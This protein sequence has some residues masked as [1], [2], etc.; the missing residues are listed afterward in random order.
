[1]TDRAFRFFVSWVVGTAAL[2]VV[3]GAV[4]FAV[5][6]GRSTKLSHTAVEEYIAATYNIEVVCNDGKDMPIG[7]G[8]S[9]PCSGSGVIVEVRMLDGVGT[10]EIDTG[11]SNSTTS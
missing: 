8:R 11:A 4:T 1:M 2:I 9:Y 3:V 6:A 7:A 5:L 10:Y